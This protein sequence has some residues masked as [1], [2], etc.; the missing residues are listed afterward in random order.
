MQKINRILAFSVQQ[1]YFLSNKSILCRFYIKPDFYYLGQLHIDGDPHQ[2]H[3]TAG[4]Q[5]L[6]SVKR[7]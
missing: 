6:W 1:Y 4:Y 2:S 3:K 7:I 5:I